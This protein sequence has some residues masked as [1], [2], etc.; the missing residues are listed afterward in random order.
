MIDKPY[1]LLSSNMNDVYFNQTELNTVLLRHV[2]FY[3]NKGISRYVIYKNYHG[4][5]I[6]KELLKIKHKIP[7]IQIFYIHNTDKELFQH[8]NYLLCLFSLMSTCY[9]NC[10]QLAE[11]YNVPMKNIYFE[12]VDRNVKP[13][14][15]QYLPIYTE[16][17]DLFLELLAMDPDDDQN[18]QPRHFYIME[19]I[20]RL[21]QEIEKSL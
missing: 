13:V 12:I 21:V 14:K 7:Q 19:Q 17:V 5:Y 1:I 3:L 2:Q 11:K 6:L 10:V 20:K 18:V 16:T 8:A 9:S 4:Q 15:E